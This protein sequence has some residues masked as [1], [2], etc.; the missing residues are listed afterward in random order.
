PPPAA[1]AA[2]ARPPRA[3]APPPTAAPAGPAKAANAV[4]LFEAMARWPAG[5]GT[6]WVRSDF[7]PSA[8]VNI[9]PPYGHPLPSVRSIRRP[10]SLALAAAWPSMARNSGDINFRFFAAPFPVPPSTTKG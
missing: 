7:A 2:P 3:P 5:A 1:P 6:T 10:I 9:G 8:A 4:G